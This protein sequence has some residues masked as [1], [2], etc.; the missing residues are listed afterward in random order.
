[1]VLVLFCL[2]A[3][4]FEGREPPAKGVGAKRRKEHRSGVTAHRSAARFVVVVGVE[5]NVDIWDRSA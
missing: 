2:T 5:R 1:M 3:L 4:V